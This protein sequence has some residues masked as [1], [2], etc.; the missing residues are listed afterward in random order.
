[1]FCI[2]QGWRGAALAGWLVLGASSSDA[3]TPVRQL[4][5]LQSLERGNL[6]L[7]QF[8]GNFRVD[9]DQRAGSPVNVV[10][11]VVGPT[12]FVGA[13][14]QAVVDYIRSTFPDRRK[15]D[16]IVTLGGVA[17]VFARKHRQQ[18]FSDTP[19][20]FAAV[21]ERFLGQA[22]LDE[23][24]TAV[25]SVNDFPRLVETILQ[26]LPETRQVFMVMG[27]GPFREF[28]RPVIEGQFRELQGRVTFVRSDDLSSAEILRRCASLPL[29]SAISSSASAQTRRAGRMRT[30]ACSP[31]CTPRRTAPCLR[32]RVSTWVSEL[33]AAR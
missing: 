32:C 5:L 20:L 16:L 1:M 31:T 15:P 14:E 7:D 3:Q 21:D 24:E 29:H 25:P 4:L 8:T 23:Y 27:A 12:G 19:V 13:P 33:S 2:H 10:Q 30:S 26:L 11:V 18:L 9:L 28:W 17:A 6:V 22:P